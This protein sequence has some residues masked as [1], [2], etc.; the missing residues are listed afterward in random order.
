MTKTGHYCTTISYWCINI[1]FDDNPQRCFSLTLD[2][3]VYNVAGH[4][5]CSFVEAEEAVIVL[6]APRRSK[7]KGVAD[8]LVLLLLV[9]Q[10]V[11]D[12]G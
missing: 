9:V 10:L 1:R 6:K 8:T 5:W 12:R 4:L 2:E 11:Q 3:P 7:L